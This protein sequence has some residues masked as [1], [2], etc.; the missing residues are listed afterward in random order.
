MRKATTGP[1]NVLSAKVI[2]HAK[3]TSMRVIRAKVTILPNGNKATTKKMF[4]NA[5][6]ARILQR[7]EKLQAGL[8][9]NTILSASKGRAP[10][11]KDAKLSTPE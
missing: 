8:A 1:Q 6:I 11:D 5:S 10:A 9:V 3:R 2:L 4:N 7:V